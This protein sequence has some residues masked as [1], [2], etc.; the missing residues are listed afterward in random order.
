VTVRQARWAIVVVA[1]A[2]L[3]VV[4]R[5]RCAT[6]AQSFRCPHQERRIVDGTGAPWFRADLGIAGDRIAAVGLLDGASAAITIDAT[7][8]VVALDSSI[9]WA[10]PNSKRPGGRTRCQQ[11]PARQ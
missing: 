10:N 5:Q 9:C 3:F 4:M 2:A 7:N 1:V 6:S 8:L 11:D